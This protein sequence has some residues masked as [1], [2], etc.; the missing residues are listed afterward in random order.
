[1]LKSK[2]LDNEIKVLFELLKQIEDLKDESQE[3]VNLK[4]KA[5]QFYLLVLGEH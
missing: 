2:L 3:S 1:M 4:L 5:I